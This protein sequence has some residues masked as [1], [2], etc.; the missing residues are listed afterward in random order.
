MIMY[1]IIVPVNRIKYKALLFYTLYTK[2]LKGKHST[3]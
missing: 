1:K 2:A 3:T